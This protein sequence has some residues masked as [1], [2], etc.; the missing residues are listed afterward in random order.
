[1]ILSST[2]QMVCIMSKP[3]NDYLCKVGKS[4]QSRLSIFNTANQAHILELFIKLDL[5]SGMSVLDVACGTGD[6]TCQMAERYPEIRVVGIDFSEEQINLARETAASKKL[7]NVIFIVMSACDIIQLSEKYQF[8]RIF[9]RWVLGHLKEPQRVIE[10]CKELIKPRGLILCEE[11]DLQTHHCETTNQSF[12]QS[13]GLFVSNIL[14]LQRKRGVDAEIG[15]KLPAMFRAVFNDQAIIETDRHQLTLKSVEEKE[16]A[17]TSF[18]DE[19]GQR[20]ID[21][22]VLTEDQLNTLKLNLNEIVHEDSAHISYTED[23]AVV[24]KLR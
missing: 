11:G 3:R 14:N 23:T 9:I 5:H 1:M 17:S 18:L 8:D 12:Q 10:S 20:F 13:Y 21:E 7:G 24:V 6:I 2:I 22:N 4:G 19:V 15:K 16:A